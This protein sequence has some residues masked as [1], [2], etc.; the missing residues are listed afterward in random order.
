M[1]K[2]LLALGLIAASGPALATDA[3]VVDVNPVL[4]DQVRYEDV[5][6]Q[7]LVCGY[8]NQRGNSGWIERGTNGVFGSTEGLLGAA[9]GTA[10][11]NEIGGGSGNEAAK[12]IGGVLG[13]KIGNNIAY[14]KGET[15]QEV[16]K[17]V[18]QRYTE[19]VISGYNVLVDINGD[20]YWVKRNF[21]PMVGDVINVRVSV[22]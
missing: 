10:I 12:V 15:C 5:P 18:R 11:G 20:H 7:Q 3:Y 13:N 22:R 6:T 4:E 1:K 16:T 14:K 19:T 21:E 8:S 2:T 17:M 9:I